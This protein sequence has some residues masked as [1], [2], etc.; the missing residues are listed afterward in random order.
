MD[1]E[2]LGAWFCCSKDPLIISALKKEGRLVLWAKIRG[3]CVEQ[4][5]HLELV[6]E[7]PLACWLHTARVATRFLIDSKCLG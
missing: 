4:A 6:T 5:C 7:K 3:I 1:V 2:R